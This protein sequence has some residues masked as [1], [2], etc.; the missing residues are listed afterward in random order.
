[1]RHIVAVLGAAVVLSGL[2]VSSA[3]AGS[4]D[5]KVRIDAQ[6]EFVS[7]TGL[8]LTVTYDCPEGTDTE[9]TAA[10][11]QPD[12]GA[13]GSTFAPIPVTCTGKWETIVVGILSLGFPPE[14]SFALGSAVASAGVS[15]GGGLQDHRERS[16]RIVE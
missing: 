5:I 8:L 16:V 10:V 11:S 15:A 7:S 2:T 12:T 1:M 6:A 14:A 3:T 9:L 13:F 4:S